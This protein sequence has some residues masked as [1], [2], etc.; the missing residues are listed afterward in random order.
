MSSGEWYLLYLYESFDRIII[1]DIVI[2][3]KTYIKYDSLLFERSEDKRIWNE[4]CRLI[5]EDIYLNISR[6]MYDRYLLVIVNLWYL[7]KIEVK[8]HVSLF[9][10]LFDP[11]SDWSYSDNYWISNVQRFYYQSVDIRSDILKIIPFIVWMGKTNDYESRD[12]P[13]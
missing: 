3:R 2:F 5:F 8:S 11:E 1:N 7:E 6:S 9:L 12:L 10:C 4:A 13:L